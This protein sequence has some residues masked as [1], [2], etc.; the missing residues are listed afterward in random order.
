M[1]QPNNPLLNRNR[2]DR[3]NSLLSYDDGSQQ[4]GMLVTAHLSFFSES[5]LVLLKRWV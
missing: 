2:P 4:A 1:K 3:S 5:N